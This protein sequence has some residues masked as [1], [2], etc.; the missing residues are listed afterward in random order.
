MQYYSKLDKFNVFLF[1]TTIYLDSY[2]MCCKNTFAC[3]GFIVISCC[4]CAWPYNTICLKLEHDMCIIY[5]CDD[6]FIKSFSLSR[7]MSQSSYAFFNRA[8]LPGK[9]LFMN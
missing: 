6:Y 1:V 2:G 9:K 3:S 5:P 4:V 8:R 7:I